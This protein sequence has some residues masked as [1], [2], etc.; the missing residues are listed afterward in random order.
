MRVNTAWKHHT[1]GRIDDLGLAIAE[2]TADC[3]NDAIHDEDV[4]L[5]IV[6]RRDNTAIL[7]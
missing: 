7:H 2:T 1:A 3:C 4:S 5:I 6:Y